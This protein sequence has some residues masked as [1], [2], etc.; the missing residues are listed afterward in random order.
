MLQDD[1]DPHITIAVMAGMLTQEQGDAYKN[2]DKQYKPIR[3]IA[4][5]GNYA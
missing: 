3:D 1:F 5:N 4:K 2:G